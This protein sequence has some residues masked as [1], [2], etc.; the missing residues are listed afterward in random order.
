M[1]KHRD[2]HPILL[3]SLCVEAPSVFAD[4]FREISERFPACFFELPLNYDPRR[5]ADEIGSETRLDRHELAFRREDEIRENMLDIVGRY[6][7]PPFLCEFEFLEIR[8]RIRERSCP[9]KPRI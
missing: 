8:R 5:F 2:L 4:R 7:L 1:S 6:H 9:R 3:K